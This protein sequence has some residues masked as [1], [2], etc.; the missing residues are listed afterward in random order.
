[1]VYQPTQ[2]QPP[3]PGEYE[4]YSAPPQNNKKKRNCCEISVQYFFYFFCIC[5]VIRLID[6]LSGGVSLGGSCTHGVVWEDLPKQFEYDDGLKVSVVGG[7]ITGGH[8]VIKSIEESTSEEDGAIVKG[9]IKPTVMI[10]PAS[11]G[12]SADISY[13]E[14]HI[15]NGTILE[16]NVPQ[17]LPSGACVS[18]NAV[19]YVPKNSG[20]L[21][22]ELQN[23][24][25]EVTDH[26]LDIE[27]VLLQTTNQAI[28]Y[29]PVWQG[30][31]LYLTTTNALI[32]LKQPINN[33]RSVLLTTSNA[34]IRAR[35]Y[36]KAQ[37]IISMT[38]S[39]GAID[40]DDTLES[41]QVVNLES[42]NAHIS[43]HNIKAYA[44]N[45]KTSNGRIQIYHSYVSG[46]FNVQT[47]NAK[48][49]LALNEGPHTE[50]VASTSNGGI[51]TQFV[52]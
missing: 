37:K 48:L 40:V 29:N 21:I 35:S 39:N 20:F 11:L 27:K 7:H 49:N 38:T 31:D 8:I 10:S 45:V 33:S 2:R 23:S 14:T 13:S 19:I 9:I 42:T 34:P 50:V 32:D 30:E 26:R 17:N 41:N 5:L 12:R 43:A 1:M 51:E 47:S 52:S 3:P 46:V 18:L 16:I 4:N 24:R 6:L 28:E 44:S 25:I 36:I 15:M 22:L